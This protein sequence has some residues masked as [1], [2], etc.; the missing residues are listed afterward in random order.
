MTLYPPNELKRKLAGRQPALGYWL[1]LRSLAVTEMAAGL[2][3]DWLLLDM[4]HVIH[5]VE[6]VE[7]HLLAARHA[8]SQTE[9]V[10][11]VPSI[12]PALVKRLLDGGVRSFMFPLVQTVEE[13]RLAVASTRYPPKGIRGFSGGTRATRWGRDT[14]YL[15]TYEDD[16]CVILQI[17]SPETIPNIAAFGAMDGVDAML[18][19]ANDLAANC[20]HLGDTSHPE[21]IKVFDEAALQI[22]ATGKATGFQFFNQ[23]RAK[24]LMDRGLTLAAVAGDLDT[25]TRA[26]AAELAAYR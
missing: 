17:E 15:S 9:L 2:G 11:R 26:S 23:Q 19:G 16:I 4:E 1:S 14:S 21:V 13:A 22:L 8:S 20:G 3:W 24:G 7:Q 18:I 12:D 6:T 25:L 10:V 5:D